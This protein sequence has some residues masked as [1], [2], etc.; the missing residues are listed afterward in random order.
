MTVL[1]SHKF[2]LSTWDQAMGPSSSDSFTMSSFMLLCPPTFLG[3][4]RTGLCP[5]LALNGQSHVVC[6]PCWEQMCPAWPAPSSWYP[7]LLSYHSGL[8][9]DIHHCLHTQVLCLGISSWVIPCWCC[10]HWKIWFPSP[11][12]T[13]CPDSGQGL[14][15]RNLVSQLSYLEGGQERRPRGSEPWRYLTQIHPAFVL[16]EL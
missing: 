11:L 7:R 4:P 16:Q 15:K 1:R 13:L 8:L 14:L 2:L 12:P 6:L 9:Y 5:F 3:L 10:G